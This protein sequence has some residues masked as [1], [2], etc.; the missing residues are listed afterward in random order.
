MRQ[1][2]RWAGAL[3][4]LLIATPLYA[5]DAARASFGIT[6]YAGYMKFG[7]IVNGPLGTSLRNA[8]AAVYGAELSLGLSRNVALVGNL[9]YARP[10]LEVGLPV[11]GG[12]SVG[13]SSVLLYDAGLRLSVPLQSGGLPITPFVQA[14]AGGIRQEVRVSPVETH[15]SDFAYNFGGGVDLA[16]SPRLGLQVMA[17]DY[18][19]KF[20]AS[21][22]R[23]IGV[24][25]RTTHNWALSAGVRLGL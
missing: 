10:N 21:E 20:G 3:A 12:L 19:G 14:G 4:G 5:Q 9:G 15:S 25:S 17:K 22:A 2:L 24:D 8:G 18:I 23:T 7:N 16:L 1:S 6:P 11:V 13:E